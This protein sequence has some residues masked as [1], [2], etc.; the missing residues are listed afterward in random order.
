[1]ACW[2][3]VVLKVWIDLA[4]LRV[5][6]RAK[7]RA[8]HARLALGWFSASAISLY[9]TSINHLFKNIY[10]GGVRIRNPLLYPAELRAQNS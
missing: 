6:A 3:T 10:K 5:L 9:F 8:K 1:M 4:I 2:K 7:V